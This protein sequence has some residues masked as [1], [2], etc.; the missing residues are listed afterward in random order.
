MFGLF[1][2]KSKKDKMLEQ[3]KKLQEEAFKL[4]RSDRKASDLKYAEAQDL[5]NEID[6][7]PEES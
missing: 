6:Q 7:L 3:Y 1:K 2:S 5:L 4:S